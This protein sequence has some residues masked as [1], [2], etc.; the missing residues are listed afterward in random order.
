MFEVICYTDGSCLGNP[1]PSG[2]AGILTCKGKKHVVKGHVH[3]GTNNSAELMAVIEAMKALNKPCN[4]EFHVDSQ[5]V[6]SY[7][8]HDEQWLTAANRPNRD[9]WLELITVVKN[10]KHQI[11]FVKVPGHAGN[12]LNEMCDKLAREEAKKAL[13]EIFG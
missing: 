13:H 2:Y 1:G 11:K 6:M 7:N 3:E 12:E 8:N 4:V 9:L 10:G 5:Y